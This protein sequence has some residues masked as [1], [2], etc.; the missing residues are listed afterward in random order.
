MPIIDQI[1]CKPEGKTEAYNFVPSMLGESLLA[2]NQ[3]VFEDLDIIQLGID[4][5]DA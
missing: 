4:K 2:R 1:N 5:T 3:S